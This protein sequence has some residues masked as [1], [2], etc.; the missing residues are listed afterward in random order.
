VPSLALSTPT[1]LVPVYNPDMKLTW[2]SSLNTKW[3]LL[4][5]QVVPR[6]WPSETNWSLLNQFL[7]REVILFRLRKGSFARVHLTLC[8]ADK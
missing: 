4:Q 5:L 3:S 2:N 7:S 8:H 1:T 6:W